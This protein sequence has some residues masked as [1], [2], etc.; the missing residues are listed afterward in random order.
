MLRTD[1]GEAGG[2]VGPI[3]Q[4]KKVRRE[5]QRKDSVKGKEQQRTAM[6][7]SRYDGHMEAADK[8][9]CQHVSLKMR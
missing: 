1:G 5:K 7:R 9:E 3:L 4:I 2:G 6:G 8:E